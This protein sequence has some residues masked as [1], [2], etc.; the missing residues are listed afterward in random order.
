MMHAQ[1][2]LL[3]GQNLRNLPYENVQEC[4][5]TLAGI[6]AIDY[7]SAQYTLSL[8][9]TMPAFEKLSQPL[10]DLSFHVLLSLSYA[11]RQGNS[12][13]VIDALANK[14]MWSETELSPIVGGL[15]KQGYQFPGPQHL[16]DCTAAFAQMFINIDIVKLDGSRLYTAKFY[17]YEQ[18]FCEH[19]RLKIQGTDESLKGIQASIACSAEPHKEIPNHYLRMQQCWPLLFAHVSENNNTDW[20]QLAVSNALT[21]RF[22]VISGGAGTGKTYTLSRIL[23]VLLYAF[24]LHARRIGF[25]APT[26]KAANRLATSLMQ[27]M[28]SLTSRSDFAKYQ[29]MLQY[30]EVQ[31]VHRLLKIHPIDGRC[32]YDEH[33]PLPFDYLILDEAS[34]VDLSLMHKLLRATAANCK[35]IMVGDPNQLP[36]VDAGCLLAD[37]VACGAPVMSQ[38]RAKQLLSLNPNLQIN[39]DD[40]DR[41]SEPKNQY[42]VSLQK[43]KRSNQAVYDFAHAVLVG[44]ATAVLRTANQ[45]VTLHHSVVCNEQVN[46]FKQLL[47]CDVVP[48]LA[49]SLS[50]PHLAQAWEALSQYACLIPNRR[51]FAGVDWVNA[52]VEYA[53]SRRF[54]WVELGQAYRGKPIMISQN[55]YN[56]GLFN[57]DIGIIWPDDKGELWAYFPSAQSAEFQQYSLYTLPAYDAVFAMTIHKT[58]GSEYQHVD[59]ILPQHSAQY[60][61][62]E[63]LYTGVTRAKKQLRVFSDEQT[64][65]AAVKQKVERVSGVERLLKWDQKNDT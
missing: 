12:C 33:R 14:H 64:L 32:K 31:T 4:L 50:A 35:V 60:L 61:T 30:I 45:S 44:D 17:Q 46:A 29:S 59:V 41:S 21:S 55:D 11:Q 27:E 53:L 9:Q 54:A 63:L 5:A 36:S 23:M 1:A 3:G 56:L 18:Q 7:F 38:Q 2:A 37:L 8:C 26:G 24:D 58:Q 51:G 15:Q 49:A 10:K 13:L 34:M 43:G 19:L 42:L 28:I 20:Q 25:V 57:G 22:S 52:Y 16:K 62:R 40:F 47:D 48:Q 6:E 65:V 39:I